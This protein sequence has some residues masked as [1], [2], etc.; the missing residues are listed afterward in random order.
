MTR[1]FLFHLWQRNTTTRNVVLSC[2]PAY[3]DNLEVNKATIR[4]MKLFPSTTVIAC[5]FLNTS[6]SYYLPK[7]AYIFSLWHYMQLLLFVIHGFTILEWGWRSG[8]FP[9][10][11]CNSSSACKACCLWLYQPLIV[12]SIRLSG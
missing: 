5:R 1:I 4:K 10:F 8:C 12:K 9:R 2:C 3:R 7:V 11:D 6:L